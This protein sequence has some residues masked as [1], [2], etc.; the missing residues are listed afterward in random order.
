MKIIS[1]LII[2]FISNICIGQVENRETLESELERLQLKTA[3]LIHSQSLDEFPIWSKNSDY[4]GFNLAGNWQKI[5]LKNIE[6]KE[7]DWRNSKIGYLTTE[8]AFSEMTQEEITE[9]QNSSKFQPREA[10][11]SDGTKIELKMN[12]MRVSLIITKKGLKQ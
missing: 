3:L 4:I 8:N 7:V 6:L 1:S 12:G 11:T 9:F 5:N 2:L 10:T